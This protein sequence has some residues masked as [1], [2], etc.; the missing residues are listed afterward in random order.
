VDRFIEEFGN[1]DNRR[2]LL[3]LRARLVV[4][5]DALTAET[6]ALEAAARTCLRG[7]AAA[8]RAIAA[9]HLPSGRKAGAHLLA[10]GAKAAWKEAEAARKRAARL[11]EEDDFHDLRKAVKRHWTHLGLLQDFWPGAV[12]Q[13]RK[14]VEALGEELGELNDIYVMEAL[15]RA[16]EIELDFDAG[17]Q[18]AEL[19][20]LKREALC[21]AALADTRRLFGDRPAG[22]KAAFEARLLPASDNRKGKATRQTEAA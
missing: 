2:V 7:C 9:W 13:R 1:R 3:T 8:K 12:K 5:L 6:S 22:L 19:L 11:G 17:G 14:A 4:K 15:M 21:A 18:F 16:G 20:A 10:R